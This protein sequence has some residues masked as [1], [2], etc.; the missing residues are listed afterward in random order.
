MEV[1]RM[2]ITKTVEEMLVEEGAS[3]TGVA[4]LSQITGNG[5]S[6]GVAVAVRIP[7]DII[8]AIGDGPTLEYFE[9]Y[10]Q[11]NRTLNELVTKGASYLTELGYTAVAQTTDYVT[12]TEDYR[13]AIPH[14]TVATNAGLGWI[15]KSALFVTKEYGSA[16]RLSSI[17]TNAPLEC[18]TAVTE[19][20]CGD[21]MECTN[22][23]PGKAIS[24][25][26]WSRNIDRDEFFNPFACRKKAREL[27]RR[28]IEKEITL[29]GKCIEVCPY[30]KKYISS[31]Q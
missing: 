10:H 6:R 20:R 23:C 27:A 26:L 28:A 13:T 19:S 7:V 15:G 9:A 14:K 8:S 4:D 29:C 24:G 21:C 30:T 2:N 25:K 22:A 12:E 3:L 16:V 17:L 18:G 31:K 11:L 5:W 1:G